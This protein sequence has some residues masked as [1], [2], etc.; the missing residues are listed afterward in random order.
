MHAFTFKLES[1]YDQV[2][3]LAISDGDVDLVL[4]FGLRELIQDDLLQQLR[5]RFPGA[6]VAGCSS[7]GEFYNG[8][9][10]QNTTV[11][12]V[13]SFEKSRCE[14]AHFVCPSEGCQGGTGVAIVERLAAPDLKAV[15]FFGDG[16]QSDVD[17]IIQR[18]RGGFGEVGASPVIFGGKAGDNLKFEETVVADTHGIY[19]AGVVAVG[20]YGEGL[21]IR[22]STSNVW[23]V[24]G[25]VLD[26][27]DCDANLIR[28]INDRPA[29]TVY[30]EILGGKPEE[31][32]KDSGFHPLILIGEDGEAKYARTVFGHDEET[33]ALICAGNI[34]GRIQVGSMT[35][36]TFLAGVGEVM[37]SVEDPSASLLLTASCVGRR[38]TLGSEVFEEAREIRRH[39]GGNIP[40]AG[41]YCYG[42][43]G[44]CSHL[45]QSHFLNHSFT[46]LSLREI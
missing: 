25:D 21:A 38:L 9:Y 44:Y 42:E 12:V 29:A 16:L 4:F 22:S 34:E 27:T 11:V 13:V 5:G 18:M 10:L 23:P 36:E 43:V 30:A 6:Q 37:G 20:L 24:I 40:H 31:V 19:N 26:I 7:A 35:R 8:E 2:P 45:D 39:I 3:T 33:G 17:P 41:L 14:S 46:A 28:K 32:L 1:Q 15:L